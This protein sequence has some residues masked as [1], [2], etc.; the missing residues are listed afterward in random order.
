MLAVFNS[1]DSERAGPDD[2]SIPRVG[3]RGMNIDHVVRDRARETRKLIG[4]VELDGVLV[5]LLDASRLQMQPAVDEI[6]I[7]CENIV[8]EGVNNVVRRHLLVVM[9]GDTLSEFEHPGRVVRRLPVGRKPRFRLHIF[10][11]PDQWFDNACPV[12]C[13]PAPVFPVPIACRVQIGHDRVRIRLIDTR[14]STACE[15]DSAS[16][17]HSAE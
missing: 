8:L 3:F 11:S 9:E 14:S 2:V 4:V 7:L 1:L 12:G 15:S 5:D 10:R 16:C 17:C 6:T 13:H